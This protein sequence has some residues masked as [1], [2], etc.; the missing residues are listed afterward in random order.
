ML[1]GSE[2]QRV[3]RTVSGTWQAVKECELPSVCPK[4][5]LTSQRIACWMTASIGAAWCWP[6]AN[7]PSKG[8]RMRVLTFHGY[9]WSCYPKSQKEF[10]YFQI[11]KC[12]GFLFILS[13]IS[14]LIAFCSESMISQILIL[15]NF[16]ETCLFWPKRWPVFICT[17]CALKEHGFQTTTPES[18]YQATSPHGGCL[19]VLM[20]I[21]WS[22]IFRII[23][24]LSIQ[25]S[26]SR[27]M[28]PHC[29]HL[30]PRSF[31]IHPYSEGGTL[32]GLALC[33]LYLLSPESH[34]A[35]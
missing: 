12:I 16:F 19:M 30:C 28:F 31:L 34:R 5:G 8:Y 13:L 2:R 25:S 24:F 15:W 9:A 29:P 18:T 20:T 14:N 22:W 21:L 1:K 7:T 33:A 35:S 23:F 32:W 4:N 11:S 10:L 26:S 27:R 17:V 3:Y 6:T